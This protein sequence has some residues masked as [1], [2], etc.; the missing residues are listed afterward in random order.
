MTDLEHD[1]RVCPCCGAKASVSLFDE[2][3]AN[4]GKCMIICSRNGCKQVIAE[5]VE[6]AAKI[7]NEPRFTDKI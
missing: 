4:R 6:E 7:W 3:V 1:L 5:D 2:S